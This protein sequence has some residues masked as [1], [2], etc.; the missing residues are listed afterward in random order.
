MTWAWCS[1]GQSHEIYDESIPLRFT[2]P[3]NFLGL[4]FPSIFLGWPVSILKKYTSVF[5]N[6]LNLNH[7]RK[8]LCLIQWFNF[9]AAEK[10]IRIKKSFW[11]FTNNQTR[12]FVII[13]FSGNSNVINLHNPPYYFFLQSHITK[14]HL[15]RNKFYVT[16]PELQE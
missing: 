13:S 1:S 8:N 10:Y 4:L 5:Q 7:G 2:M 14:L 12:R 3:N 15:S 9:F 11:T 6:V 16:P